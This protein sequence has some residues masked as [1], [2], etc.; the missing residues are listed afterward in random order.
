MIPRDGVGRNGLKTAA[1]KS[2]R[3]RIPAKAKVWTVPLLHKVWELLNVSGWE[4][5]S[6][7]VGKGFNW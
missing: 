7:G 2:C 6:K 5:R 4:A 1:R 3:R